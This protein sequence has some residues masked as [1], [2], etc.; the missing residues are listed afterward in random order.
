[1]SGYDFLCP[2][3]FHRTRDRVPQTGCDRTLLGRVYEDTDALDIRRLHKTLK[4]IEFAFSLGRISDH[5]RRPDHQTV[6]LFPEAV[7]QLPDSVAFPGS[8]H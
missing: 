2:P 7:Y 6:D 1:M 8:T 4:F 5:K 3:L